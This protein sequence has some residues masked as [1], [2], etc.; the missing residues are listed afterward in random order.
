MPILPHFERISI[1]SLPFSVQD[2]EQAI[3]RNKRNIFTNTS[4]LADEP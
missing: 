3:D 2:C 1:K 4:S